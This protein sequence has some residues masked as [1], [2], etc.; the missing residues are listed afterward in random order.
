M[1]PATT[2]S[3]APGL[4]AWPLFGLFACAARV[5][6]RH[7]GG[8]RKIMRTVPARTVLRR[9]GTAPARSPSGTGAV[10]VRHRRG[11]RPAPARG[12]LRSEA[13]IIAIGPFVAPSGGNSTGGRHALDYRRNP[14]RTMAAR[15]DQWYGWRSDPHP[16]RYRDHRGS[17]SRHT[18]TQTHLTAAPFCNTEGVSPHGDA[19]SSRVVAIPPAVTACCLDTFRTSRSFR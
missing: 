8:R 7:S 15:S 11:P 6:D 9:R 13:A 4:P 1:Q 3:V 2:G 19:P 14:A 16:A 5:P 17:R 18:G 10:P 12:R